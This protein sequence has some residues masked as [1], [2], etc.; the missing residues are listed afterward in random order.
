MVN[1]SDSSE[2]VSAAKTARKRL[3]GCV[4]PESLDS[5]EA[6]SIVV[7]PLPSREDRPA[8]S[9]SRSAADVRMYIEGES[10]GAA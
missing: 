4:R 9:S 1:N 3:G 5:I 7:A 6:S 8:S 10:R 2:V